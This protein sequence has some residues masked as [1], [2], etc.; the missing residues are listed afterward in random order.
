MWIGERGGQ[1]PGAKPSKSH[2]VCQALSE[3]KKGERG[4][5]RG[6]EWRSVYLPPYRA[7]VCVCVCAQCKGESAED[8]WGGIAAGVSMA[9][10][11]VS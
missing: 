3:D 9:M 4:S 1:L 2:V 10:M 8:E 5:D 11:L 6:R 7:T